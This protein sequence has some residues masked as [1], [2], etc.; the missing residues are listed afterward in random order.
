MSNIRAAVEAA[1]AAEAEDVLMLSPAEY[2]EVMSL[3]SLRETIKRLKE[4]EEAQTAKIR[5]ILG[6]STT[7][8]YNGRSAVSQARRSRTTVDSKRLKAEYPA[9]FTA[10]SGSVSYIAVSVSA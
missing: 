1:E 7:G 8:I 2:A 9:V 4:A 3:K 6:D 10:V 5:N